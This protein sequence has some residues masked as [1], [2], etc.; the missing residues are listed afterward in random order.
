MR[1]YRTKN[2]INPSLVTALIVFAVIICLF[3]AGVSDTAKTNDE[4]A[5]QQLRQ[6]IERAAKNCYAAEGFY[7]AGVSYLE[8]HYGVKIDRDKY[9]VLYELLGSNIMPYVKIV[10]VGSGGAPDEIQ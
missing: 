8:E 4:Q 2:R 10:K 6:N 3:A 1:L 9:A 5:M 7:P